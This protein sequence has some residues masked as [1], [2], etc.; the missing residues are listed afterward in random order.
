MPADTARSLAYAAQSRTERL[1]AVARAVLALAALLT[2]SFD[3]TQPARYAG[4]Y[5]ILGSY[6]VHAAIVAAVAWRMY[7]WS[8]RTLIVLHGLD[9]IMFTVFIDLVEG[10]PISPFFVFFVF[11]L[12]AASLRWNWRGTL[13]TAGCA[14]AAFAGLGFYRGQFVADE[15]VYLAVVAGVLAY[16]GAHEQRRRDEVAKLASWSPGA[17]TDLR[18]VVQEAVAY[19]ADILVS[20]RV[21]LAWE[22]SEEPGLYLAH[23][24]GAECQLVRELASTPAGLVAS[25]LTESFFFCP[26]L[27]ELPAGVLRLETGALEHWH[28]APVDRAF[29]ARFAMVSVLCLPLAGDGWTGR[30]LFLDKP[31]VTADDALVARIVGQ[32]VVARLD[33]HYLV[34]RLQQS[35]IMQERTGLARDLHDGLLQ[36]LAGMALQLHLAFRLLRGAPEKAADRIQDV[37]RQIVAAQRSLRGFIRDLRPLAPVEAGADPHLSARLRRLSDEM[38]AQWGIDVALELHGNADALPEP[39]LHDVLYVVHEALSNAARHGGAGRVSVDV[40]VG[41]DAVRAV[42]ADNGVGFRFKGRHDLDDLV[43]MNAGPVS[44]RERVTTR[45]GTLVLT[46]DSGGARLEIEFPYFDPETGP[47]RPAGGP[48][49]SSGG[50]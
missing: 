41:P 16:M 32:Q 14:L 19:A 30:L 10:P 42:I 46:S 34:Q 45:G 13:A 28:D 31:R 11:S 6:V 4:T 35:A 15:I 5:L 38:E 43:R 1:I 18:S 49:P 39:R 27:S 44:I 7:R 22:E 37:R 40:E 20:P 12:F 3:P 29:Q 36:S 17:P 2:L 8:P 25:G 24:S 9:L 26:R 33:H 50:A 47:G 21:I 48:R 23:A